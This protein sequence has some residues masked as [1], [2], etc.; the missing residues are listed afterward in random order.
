MKCWS[1][2]SAKSGAEATHESGGGSMGATSSEA[3]DAVNKA[4]VV[5]DADVSY[6]VPNLS[7]EL[8]TGVDVGPLR[9]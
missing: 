4:L 9:N 5:L 8:V 1:T 6:G 3:S 7:L 2:L